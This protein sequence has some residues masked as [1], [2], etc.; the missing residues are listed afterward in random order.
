MQAWCCHC[1]RDKAMREG[2]DFDECDDNE[3]C[4]II[5]KTMFYRIDDPDYPI[6]WQ[7]DSDGIP[8]CTAFVA[9]GN[10]VPE[11]DDRTL[12]LF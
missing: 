7:Y 12:P 6:E 1:Q 8:C 2:A 11:I 5:G 4:S 3:K 9:A 10:P